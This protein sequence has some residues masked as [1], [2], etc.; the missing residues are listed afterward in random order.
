MS[1]IEIALMLTAVT[2]IGFS[3]H[4]LYL[5]K[6]V[7]VLI[8]WSIALIA[9]QIGIYLLGYETKWYVLA[10]LPFYLFAVVYMLIKM[11]K[12]INAAIAHIE[13]REKEEEAKKEIIETEEITH[14]AQDASLIT[15]QETPYGK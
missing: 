8:I 1:M 7:K 5:M 15:K 3:F 2:S 12:R 10:I 13:Q 11:K 14:S 6:D 4:L 9:V